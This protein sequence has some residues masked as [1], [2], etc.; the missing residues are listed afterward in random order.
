M[1]F[2]NRWLGTEVRHLIALEAVE[3]AGSFSGAARELGYTQSAISLQIAQ[4]ERIAG[5]RLVE[6]RAG[7]HPVTLTRAG[8]RLTRHSRAVLDQIRAAEADL[9]ALSAGEAGTICLGTFQSASAR[10]LPA[11][12]RRLRE[13]RPLVEVRLNEAPYEEQPALLASGKTDLAFALLPVDGPFETRELMQDPFLFISPAH[14]PKEANNRLPS[15]T[16]LARRPLVSWQRGPLAFEALLRAHGHQPHVVLR[17]D[18]RATVQNLV[19]EG[20]G[21]AILPRLALHLP[22]PRLV[23]VDASRHIPPRRIG[24]AWHRDRDHPPAMHALIESINAQAEQTAE[25]TRRPD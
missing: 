21:A 7:R 17:S 11:A 9:A 3:A 15:L 12:L 2:P 13:T 20:L 18:D 25:T 5:H 23:A 22:D 4:L 24:L 10:L 6:R 19:A 1:H 16:Q 14:P 8:Q